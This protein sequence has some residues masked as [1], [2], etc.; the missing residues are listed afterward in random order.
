MGREFCDALRDQVSLPLVCVG[1]AFDFHAGTKR[2]V[3][4]WMQRRG[5]EWLFRL[6]QE[7]RRLWRRYFITNSLFLLKLTL[8]VFRRR[9]LR[10]GTNHISIPGETT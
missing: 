2:T 7:P 9:V 5:L 6:I 8:T 1:A 4:R 10:A 3:P